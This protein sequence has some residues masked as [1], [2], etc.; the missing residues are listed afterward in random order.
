MNLLSK[1]ETGK[2]KKAV[3]IV[4]YGVK[5][6]GKSSFPLESPSPIY[7]GSE[8]NSELDAAKFPQVKTWADLENYLGALVKE[9]HD[10]K[11][12]VIDTVDNLQEIAEMEILSKEPAGKTMATALGGYGKAYE[13]MAN[14]FLNVR[15]TYLK[16][17]RETKGMNIILLAH[18]EKTKHE[19]PMTG[20]AWDNYQTSI[21]KKVKPIFEDWSS[22]ILFANYQITKDDDKKMADG[23]GTR[24]IWTQER[25]SH[26]AKNRFDLPFTLPF[27]KEGSFKYLM[28][29]VETFYSEKGDTAEIELEIV[30]LMP[31]MPENI[32]PKINESVEKFKGNRTEMT[33]IVEKMRGFKQ[34]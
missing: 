25:P 24:L 15:E 14:M 8:D 2:K 12:L 10:Y 6:I 19:D 28:Q 5:G 30:E 16:V 7:I 4:F 23:D 20:G 26:I 34:A 29:L 32:R 22:A 31:S 18:A 1:I 9:N 33:R 3:C 13:R 21:H 17:L 11:T 27:K